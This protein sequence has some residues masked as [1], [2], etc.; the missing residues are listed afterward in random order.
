MS[1][2]NQL[3]TVVESFE[4][5]R[6]ARNGRQARTPG[7]LREQAALLLNN[8]SSSKIC[9][10]LKISGTQLKQ[11]RLELGLT[12]PSTQFVTLPALSSLQNEQSNIE[13]RFTNGAQ[14]SLSGDISLNLITTIIREVKS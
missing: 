11:W 3:V 2:S 9:S 4:Q 10:A 8:H 14:L 1:N 6:S 12:E 5:W 7:T 13:F